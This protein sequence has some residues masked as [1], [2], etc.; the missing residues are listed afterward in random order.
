[1]RVSGS[2]SDE[3]SGGIFKT[4]DKKGLKLDNSRLQTEAKR[5]ED[6][7]S[8]LRTLGHFLLWTTTY[9]KVNL[10]SIFKLLLVNKMD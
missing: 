3:L 8:R 10:N 9:D 7:G 5:I 2:D 4:G 6:D 1:M